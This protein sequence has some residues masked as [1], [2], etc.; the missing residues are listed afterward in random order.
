MCQLI[1]KLLGIQANSE[2]NGHKDIM[3]P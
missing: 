1:Q 2:M 3:K